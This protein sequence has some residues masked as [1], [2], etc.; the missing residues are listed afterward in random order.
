MLGQKEDSG[1][2]PIVAVPTTFNALTDLMA[3]P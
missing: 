3:D 2:R 1:W